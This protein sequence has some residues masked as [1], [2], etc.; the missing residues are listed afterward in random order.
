MSEKL[1]IEFDGLGFESDVQGSGSFFLGWHNN[2]MPIC[3][4]DKEVALKLSPNEYERVRRRLISEG[5]RVKI[6]D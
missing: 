1:I 6:R 3:V 5:F 2:G 4:S